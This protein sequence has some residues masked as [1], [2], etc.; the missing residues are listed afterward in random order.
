VIVLRGVGF[1][2]VDQMRAIGVWLERELAA[3]A[4]WLREG[5]LWLGLLAGLLL[6]SLAY[7]TTPGQTIFVGG[8]AATHR[9]Y[10]DAPFLQGF[11]EP[12]PG[13]RAV[14]EWWRSS[15]LPY[16]WAKGEAAVVMPGM[17]SGRWRISVL[18]RSGRPDGS[19]VESRWSIGAGPPV[20][21][22]IAAAPRVYTLIGET[23]AGD[24]RLAMSTP[25]LVV[26]NDPRAL[27]LVVQRVTVTGI[28]QHGPRMPALRLL[29]LLA[30]CL[31]MGYGLARRL[32]LPRSWSL[33]VV[34]SAAGVFAALLIGHRAVLGVFAPALAGLAGVCY[35]LAIGLAP[36]LAA[37]ARALGLATPVGERN[38]VLAATVGAFGLRMGGLLHPYA[39]SSDLGLNVNNLIQ[40]IGGDLFLTEGLPCEAG[41][42]QAP[43]PP[44]QY[45]VLAPLRLLLGTA[46][47][48]RHYELLVQGSNALL[49]SCSVALIWLL[50]RRSGAGRRA[51][52]L[53]AGLYVVAPP[54]LQSFSVGE[55]ANIFA[56]SL[57]VPLLLFLALGAPQAHRREVLVPGAA[58]L[59]ALLLSHTGVALSTL[60]LLAAWAMLWFGL[61][62][63]ISA[64]LPKP[65]KRRGGEIGARMFLRP[66]AAPDRRAE[67]MDR[68]WWQPARL[69][70]LLGGGALA[71]LLAFVLFYSAFAHLQGEHQVAVAAQASAGL[72]CPPGYPLGEKL[73]GQLRLAVGLAGQ[74]T[75]GPSGAL[76]PLLVVGGGLGTLWLW[77]RKTSPGVVLAACW[78]GT[79]F[80]L[81]TLLASDQALRW[82]HFLFPALCLG[83]GPLL[84]AWM[85]RG[86]AGT[87][88]ALLVLLYLS[89]FGL[90]LWA[91]QIMVYGH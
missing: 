79:L 20:A 45:L 80:S 16:R 14:P 71:G 25:R 50:L 15:E 52:L 81:V 34:L 88:L 90:E 82:Q 48:R 10:D 75:F 9:R 28:G 76:A 83:A 19:A 3:L 84:A 23:S 12:E 67:G 91:R 86:R 51:A 26:P 22:T 47:E 54:L 77:L 7:Q 44:G 70:P 60:A 61:R 73:I 37:A 39:R 43:Y 58:L 53:G 57:L 46:P 89:W 30:I 87:V 56:Q 17:G 29:G 68:G 69:W 85:R 55:F 21:L 42:G 72:R 8:D 31:A 64:G 62:T 59:L 5:E 38:A 78:L 49:E 36:L 4:G 32:A 35:L 63:R 6:W 66:G 2:R 1:E 24:L 40:L 65:Q 33:L 27:G 18:A 13:E 11:N 74:A 41:L